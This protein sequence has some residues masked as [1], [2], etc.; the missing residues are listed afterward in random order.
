MV[1]TAKDTHG[2]PTVVDLVPA[3]PRVFPV[4]R[5]DADTEGLLLL[6][7]D[8]DLAHRLTHPSFGVEKEYLAQ[9]ARPP[10]TGALR[11]LREGVELDDGTTAP[12][13]ASQPEPGLVRLTI[14]EGRNRQ[15]RR[16]CEAVGHPVE[17]LVRVRIGPVTDRRLAPGAWRLAD[18]RR[19]AGPRGAPG[20]PADGREGT[21]SG[22]SR[23]GTVGPMPV[24]ALRGATTLDADAPD[25][26]RERVKALMAAL[27]ERNDLDNDQLISV[28]FTGTSDITTFH[29][30]T[31]A[32]EFGLDDVP[33]LGAQEL[34]IEG[35]LPRCVRVLLHVETDR[36]RSELRHVF[37]EGAVALRPDLT[38]D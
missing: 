2:R 32:R 6:T 27:F 10:G 9:V 22:P 3:E 1:T 24:R 12:A 34:E 14:H 30:V 11:R 4:G 13:Q 19:A 38:D 33:L 8:G 36:P 31:A 25:H 5:L 7:N 23:A 16:M 15:V 21:R 37:L 18:R 17:R 28:L 35:T 29:P 20:R 26:I